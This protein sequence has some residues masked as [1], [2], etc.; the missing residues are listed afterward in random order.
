MHNRLKAAGDGVHFS[1]LLTPHKFRHLFIMHLLY[2]RQPLKVI[3]ALMGHKDARSI[4]VY[5]RVFTLDVAASLNL[6]FSG[7]DAEAV[8]RSLPPR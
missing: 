1:V 4:E 7:Q 2:H 5:K 6:S 8:L 3:Q